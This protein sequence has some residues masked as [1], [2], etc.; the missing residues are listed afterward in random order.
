MLAALVATI[1]L[2]LAAQASAA[3]TPGDVVVYRVGTGSGALSSA[4]FPVFLN[5]Y[6]PNGTLVESVALPTST[7]GSNKPLLASGSG[8]SEGL[9]TLS[10]NGEYLIESGYDA[11]I[12]TAKISET[13]DT[14]VPR[15]V[16]RVSASGAVDTSTALT[17]VGNA[18]NP[19]GAT[20]SDG[21]TLYWSGA[22]KS[23]SGGVH[24]ATLGA[25]TSTLLSSSDTNARAVTIFGGQL[26]TSSDPTKEGINIA[27]VGTGLPTTGGQSTTNLP[28]ATAPSEPYAFSFLTL[29]LGSA[30]DT[31]YVADNGAGAIVKFGLVSGKWTKEGSVAVAA[32]TGVT[33]NDVGGVVTIFA[34]TSGSS[35]EG[36]VLYK[37]TDSSGVNGTLSGNATQIAT[38]P[39]NESFRG[40]AFAPGTTIGSGGGTPPPP[41]PTI[42][43]SESSLPAALEDPTNP[44]LGVKVED[45]GVAP[46]E[47][48]VKVHS[49]NTSVAPEA[50]ISVSGSGAQRT[51]TVTPAA[52]G[53]ATITLTVEAPGGGTA[54][55]TVAYGVSAYQG[56]A[57]D[58][59]YSGAGN[60]SSAIDVGGG[61]MVLADDESNILRLYH[62]RSSGGPVKTFDF[63]KLLPV[64]SGEIDIESAARAGNTLYWMGS[65][66]NSKKGK[67]EPDRDIV[68]AATLS[69]SGASAELTYLG[70]YM[71]LR[72]DLISWDEANG[73]PLG[74]KGSTEEGVASN[75]TGGFNAEG[76][77]FAAG[78]TSTAYV[79]FRAPQEPPNDR[80]KALLVPVTNFSSLVTAGN[81]GNTKATF[82]AALQ[83][84][85]GGLGIRE[86]RKNADDEYLVIAGTPD[87]SNS[88]FGLYKWDGNPADQPV[89]TNTA[90]S[91]VAEGAWEDIVTVPDPLAGG[92]TVE[93]LE[94]N[95]DSDWYADGLTSKTGMPSG[96]QKDLGR[97]FTVALAA[98]ATPGAPQLSSGSTPNDNGLFTLSWQPSA[99]LPGLTYTLQHENASGGWSTV[100]SGLTSAEYAFT[101][102]SP[103]GEGTW[104]Y[105][106]I[107]SA[108]GSES[109]PSPS[110]SAVVVD[111]TEP[112]APA[113]SADR[114]PDFAGN[115]GWYKDSV[116]VS[117]SA[118]GDPALSDGS[119][120]SGVNPATVPAPQTFTTDGAHEASGALADFAGNVSAA[121][122]VTVQVDASAPSLAIDCPATAAVG[123]SGVHAT[124]AAS[125]GQSGLAVDPS[126]T[127][128]ID[129]A[130]AGSVTI[131]RTASDNVGHS[132]TSSCT[133]VVE[134]TQTISG[135]LK[136]KLVI[137]SGEA[138]ELTSTAKA[139]AI[140]VQSGGA[141]DVEGA[142]TGGIKANG[143]SQIRI[144][145]ATVSGASKL[146]GTSGSVVVGDEAGCGGSS[147]KSG[148]TVTAG[149]GTVT[150]IGDQLGAKLTVTHNSGSA[151]TVTH[152]TVAK[153]LTV[154]GNS[155]TVID[156]PNSVK[157]KTK[158]Q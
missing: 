158:V 15:T 56:D 125:D 14:S 9:L 26:Y 21:K 50:G 140:E 16:G 34:T 142:S 24:V 98:P 89:L 69:G 108:E 4:A 74:F 38:A 129:T 126:G 157:G 76:L 31:M 36:G 152:N 148:L 149:S 133:T 137:K 58:R 147:F 10:A 100:A 93:L 84:S 7:S 3:L 92:S 78:S 61:Y 115:G 105:R 117:F 87:D 43:T 130:K 123:Q 2:V 119:A 55:T 49:S 41:A 77:E 48:S 95:G 124:V 40:V 32:V 71:H 22:G 33:A 86:I 151:T 143:A 101:A 65:L 25:S 23:T 82:G 139:K 75:E 37:V 47:L 81:P 136:K 57:S 46:G 128:P 153:A 94:D 150:V 113:V 90:L 12:G 111:E 5:E 120:G 67:A 146:T 11:A 51:L 107:A 53:D 29:G 121:S 52:V 131:E 68:F 134:N 104:T 35:G 80:S 122:S 156:T 97:V 59:Y 144:C 66:S 85:F 28:F 6:E 141:L 88:S 145:A 17:D 45:E 70:S 27:T 114:A 13:S 60:A 64:G 112:N 79:A 30:P 127:V 96:L 8:S 62:E 154:T 103:E 83:W 118:S 44:T 106:V 109:A 110:S 116:T 42:S 63:T 102:G 39:A 155:P 72:E 1:V 73:N 54:S 99:S 20:S 18:N 91:A 132:A 138:V 19:R 135:S